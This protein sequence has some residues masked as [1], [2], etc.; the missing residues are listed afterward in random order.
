MTRIITVLMTTVLAIGLSSASA[1]DYPHYRD[2]EFDDWGSPCSSTRTLPDTAAA[3][4]DV[5]EFEYRDNTNDVSVPPVERQP[6]P[7]SQPEPTITPKPVPENRP[8]PVTN[9]THDQR[10]VYQPTPLAEV[11]EITDKYENAETIA[12]ADNTVLPSL[13]PILWLVALCFAVISLVGL[14]LLWSIASQISILNQTAGSSDADL[15]DRVA[16]SASPCR[17]NLDRDVGVRSAA[18]GRIPKVVVSRK[19]LDTAFFEIQR[20]SRQMPGDEVGCTFVGRVDGE[21]P[22]R[23]LVLNGILTEG[24]NVTRSSG[25]HDVDRQTQ[26]RELTVLQAI[27]P[28]VGFMGDL[29]LHPGSMTR[30]SGGDYRTDVRNV[31]ESATLELILGIFTRDSRHGGWDSS[32]TA[33]HQ[34]GFRLDLYY[35]GVESGFDYV[36]IRVCISDETPMLTASFGLAD[37]VRSDPVRAQLDFAALRRLPNYEEV[38]FSTFPIDDSDRELPCVQLEHKR[39]YKAT[40]VLDA[41]P[42]VPPSVFVE[43]ADE[44]ISYEPDFLKEVRTPAVW[45]TQIAL[46]LEKECHASAT[47]AEETQ[48]HTSPNEFAAKNNGRHR[49]G[50]DQGVSS[51]L[52]ATAIHDELDLSADAVAAL[53]RS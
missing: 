34:N 7:E 11:A 10:R 45:L 27:D 50:R 44:V 5:P 9:N 25:H 4:T 14:F 46:E 2:A 48:T 43:I 20:L 6:A 39:G 53:P 21:G 19:A 35:M 12:V 49:H 33:I 18:A 30:P 37:F 8:H 28:Q 32:K 24:E 23:K 22:S 47:A 3:E 15:M 26:Q 13:S 16:R 17:G 41:N 31:K 52:A 38:V 29:H 51:Q 36:P 40:I 1:Q 42:N